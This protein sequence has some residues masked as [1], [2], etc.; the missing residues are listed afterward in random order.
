MFLVLLVAF[1]GF[2]SQALARRGVSGAEKRAIM[3][4]AGVKT[5][6]PLRC[7]RVYVST[8]GSTWAAT[9]YRGATNRPCITYA[10]D[11]VSVTHYVLGGGG[12]SSPAARSTARSRVTSRPRSSATCGCSV[13]A[14]ERKPARPPVGPVARRWTQPPE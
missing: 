7:Y 5:R 10:A 6:A 2:G 12:S 13:T 3:T 11:G 14:A 4:A 9:T 1:A 8:V